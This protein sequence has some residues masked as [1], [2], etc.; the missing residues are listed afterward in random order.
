MPITH[1]FRQ[2]P[3]SPTTEKE[4]TRES[5]RPF[6]RCLATVPFRGV[7]RLTQ[8]LTV[9]FA[10]PPAI[11]LEVTTPSALGVP[12]VPERASWMPTVS[13]R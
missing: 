7:G 2:S 10:D 5:V 12:F 13:G 6:P 11:D 3:S 4:P 9:G 8:G 1:L